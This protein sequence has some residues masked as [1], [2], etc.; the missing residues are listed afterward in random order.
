MKTGLR[1]VFVVYDKVA[2]GQED[3]KVRFNPPREKTEARGVFCFRE[4]VTG[5]VSVST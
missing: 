3:Y 1:C 2:E 5:V 4:S